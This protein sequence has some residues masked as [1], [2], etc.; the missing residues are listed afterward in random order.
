M[1]V[2]LVERQLPI[3]SPRRVG[4]MI[5]TYITVHETS[6]GTDLQPAE[7]D[8]ARYYGMLTTGDSKVGYHFL[9]EA[10]TGKPARVYQFLETTVATCH[11][12]N[13]DGNSCSIGI[14]RLVNTDTNMCRAISLQA[15]LTATLMHMYDIPISHVVPHKFWSGKECPARLLAGMYGGWSGFVE[16]VKHHLREQDWIDGVL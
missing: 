10:N 11:T 1:K 12:G 15:Q 7:K 14:E 6:L 8:F 2:E 4:K 13:P 3:D 5:P 16:M 9:V